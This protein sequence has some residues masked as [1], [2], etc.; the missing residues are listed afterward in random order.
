[1]RR[2]HCVCAKLALV[3]VPL[4]CSDDTFQNGS[5]DASV[6]T[7]ESGTGSLTG[8]AVVSPACAA[9]SQG[10]VEECR[11]CT[12]ANCAQN[13]A[14]CFGDSYQTTLDGGLCQAFGQCVMACSCGDEVCFQA[15]LDAL[16]TTGPTACTDGLAR[17]LSC[18]TSSCTTACT[19][20]AQSDAGSGTETDG[21]SDR[22]AR[23]P[24]AA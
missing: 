10:Q 21:G 22:D 24:G 4:S 8:L 18:E 16:S 17:L 9:N 15:C 5:S 23:G 2:I 7:L 13:L 14:V 1:M 20:T 3:I 12:E 19:G 11:V 6:S